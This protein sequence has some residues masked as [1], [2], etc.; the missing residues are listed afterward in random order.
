MSESNSLEIWRERKRLWCGLP[1]TFTIYRLT[2]DRLF[3]K[4]GVFSIREDEVRLYRIKDLTLRKSFLQRIF[5]LGSIYVNS[6]DSNLKNFEIKNIR[7]SDEV[8][9]ELSQLVEKERLSK[10]V[11]AREFMSDSDDE[12]ID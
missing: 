5:G 6:S 8:K 11:Q 7:N 12:E 4:T 10:R 1:W 3:I 9:E 2:D